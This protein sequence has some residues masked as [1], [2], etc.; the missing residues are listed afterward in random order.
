MIILFVEHFLKDLFF[1]LSPVVVYQ[2][3]GNSMNP[4]YKDGQKVLVK[5]KWFFCKIKK[6]D[7]IVL[8][9]PRNGNLILKRIG[10]KKDKHYFVEGDNVT[11]STDSRIFGWVL[12][13]NIVGKVILKSF[14]CHPD[15]GTSGGISLHVR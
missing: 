1:F 9:D 2:I 8:H 12:E 7:V 15:R 14:P 3:Q 5:K 13:K 4:L 10:K 11:E 6:K